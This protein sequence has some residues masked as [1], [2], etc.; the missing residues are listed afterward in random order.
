MNFEKY[1]VKLIKKASSAL[2]LKIS[3]IKYDSD[4][5]EFEAGGVSM[6]GYFIRQ[7]AGTRLRLYFDIISKKFDM[8]DN[9]ALLEA[10][11]IIN[12]FN[13][14]EGGLLQLVLLPNEEEE[15]LT[16]A[17][18]AIDIMVIQDVIKNIEFEKY[19]TNLLVDILSCTANVDYYV[20]NYIEELENI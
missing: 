17:I 10:F 18:K 15:T 13:L 16:P 14:L 19:V 11:P 7:E 2:N 3:D 12:L 20:E 1:F 4:N 9:E 5:I 8:N 6:Y